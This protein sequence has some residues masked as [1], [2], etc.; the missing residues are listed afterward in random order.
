MFSWFGLFKTLITNL[1][2]PDQ[3]TTFDNFFYLAVDANDRQQYEMLFN[4][5]IISWWQ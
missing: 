1:L 4:E 2:A 5:A 3:K